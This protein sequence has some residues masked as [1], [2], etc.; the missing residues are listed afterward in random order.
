MDCAI[1]S[2]GHVNIVLGRLNETDKRYLKEQM[3]ILSNL[4]NNDTSKIGMIPS[5]SRDVPLIFLNN[6]KKFSLITIV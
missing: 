6:V 3:E 5:A 4:T 1:N 2:P